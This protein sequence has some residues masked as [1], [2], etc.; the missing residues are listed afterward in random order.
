MEKKNI[1]IHMNKIIILVI[2]IR[3][4]PDLTH[5]SWKR[6][7]CLQRVN[8]EGGFHRHIRMFFDFLFKYMIYLT[9]MRR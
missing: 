7:R 4:L 3:F 2:L 5:D 1:Q 8:H 9:I 6:S